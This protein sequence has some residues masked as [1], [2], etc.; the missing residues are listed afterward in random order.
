MLSQLK[1]LLVNEMLVM[2][3]PNLHKLASIALT[4]P[5]STAFRAKVFSNK[6]SKVVSKTESQDAGS[7]I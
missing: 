1:E 6:L 7:Q 2:M 3:F 5:D 4:I